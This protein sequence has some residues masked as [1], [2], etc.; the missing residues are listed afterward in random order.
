MKRFLAVAAVALAA[1]A[2]YAAVAPAGPQVVTPKQFAA[3]S[4]KVAAQGKTIN[5]LKKELAAVETCAFRQAVGVA[6]FGNATTEGYVYQNPD[7]T[8]ELQTA[9]D[10]ADPNNAPGYMLLTNKQ[11]ADII[12]GGKKKP[13]SLR[14]RK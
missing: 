6:Q 2:V 8:V 10:V 7:Q 5:S 14:A 4:K 9:L 1:V 11:C 13:V 12:N 3:L